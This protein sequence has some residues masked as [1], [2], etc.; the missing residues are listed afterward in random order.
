MKRKTPFLTTASLFCCMANVTAQPLANDTVKDTYIDGLTKYFTT[1]PTVDGYQKSIQNF[2]VSIIEDSPES[3]E[4]KGAAKAQV[5]SNAQT[6]ADRYV[7]EIL[8]FDCARLLSSRAKAL[9]DEQELAGYAEITPQQLADA[10]AV[11]R[12][13]EKAEGVCIMTFYVNEDGSIS[14]IT[15]N[16]CKITHINAAKLEKYTTAEQLEIKKECMR[17]MAKEGL[18]IIRKMKRWKPAYKDGNPMRTQ[19]SQGLSFNVMYVDK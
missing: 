1:S 3:F 19:V 14:G 8:P 16:N 17:Q 9:A 4:M 10:K 12:S 7:N 6:I 18:R 5:K 11:L 13:L 2:L 15:A